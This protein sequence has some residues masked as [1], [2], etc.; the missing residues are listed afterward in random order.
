[1]FAHPRQ[2]RHIC[3]ALIYQRGQ[4]RTEDDDPYKGNR[5]VIVH[6]SGQPKVH[7][8][9]DYPK[10]PDLTSQGPSDYSK[11]QPTTFQGPSETFKDPSE[12]PSERPFSQEAD[13]VNE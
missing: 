3:Y 13:P 7:L 2:F 9:F 12:R 10:V 1:M 11:A 4:G 5:G 8:Q 6:R